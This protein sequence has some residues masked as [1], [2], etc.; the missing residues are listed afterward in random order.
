MAGFEHRI[1]D[2][3]PIAGGQAMKCENHV[4]LHDTEICSVPGVMSKQ[5]WNNGNPDPERLKQLYKNL[6]E[7]GEFCAQEKLG[8]L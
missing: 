8:M 5:E 2:W 7:S 3:L 4:F 6:V 1:S